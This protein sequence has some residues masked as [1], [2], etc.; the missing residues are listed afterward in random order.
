MIQYSEIESEVFGLKTG[1]F[2]AGDFNA[3]ALREEILAEKYDLVRIKIPAYFDEINMRLV[4]TGFPFYFAGGVR[5]LSWKTPECANVF[6]PTNKDLE[7][8]LYDGTQTESLEYIIK[9]SYMFNP[10]ATIKHRE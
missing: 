5:M 4:E 9:S 1:R 7:I 2:N 6:E 8:E 3:A 10:L